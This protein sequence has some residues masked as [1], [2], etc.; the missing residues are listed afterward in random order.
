MTSR[1]FITDGHWRKS[2]AAV[3][4]L[5]RM[6]I[7]V[8]VGESTRLATAAFSKYCDRVVV[9]PS[10]LSRPSD[11][12]NFFHD[13]LSRHSFQMLLPME[14]ETLD[15][16]SRHH[17]EFSRLTYLPFVTTEK[18]HMARRK[19]KILDL[20]Q[21]QG[22]PI[23]KTWCIREISE[24]DRIKDRLP[25]PVV[26]KPR[27]GSGAVGITYARHPAD[28]INQYLSVHRRFPYPLVQE[29]IPPEGPGYGASFLLDEKG[30]VKAGFVH[31]RLRDEERFL[32]KELPGYADY[33]RQ[34]R[35]R[36]VPLVW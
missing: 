7:R 28:L 13:A 33:R 5:G 22:I 10:P 17:R 34:V 21:E 29:R 9:Y 35:Y 18:L 2:L 11:F 32:A 3:R 14:D 15:L 23:P 8:T 4:G 36:L 25:Y 19:D 20:A 1:V 6:G 26:I 30:E 16:I 27:I 31:K 12:L 24:L